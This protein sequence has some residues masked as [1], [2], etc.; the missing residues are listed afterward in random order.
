MCI[1][2]RADSPHAAEFSNIQE[3]VVL[4]D[5]TLI[6]KLKKDDANFPTKLLIG[7]LPAAL[8]EKNHD[9]SHHPV[10]SG[11]IQPVSYTHLDV[12]KRQ[13]DCRC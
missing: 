7:I 10:G 6:F 13:G 11:S 2:D 4:N 9:F 3:I 5:D 12:Y 1:R 8:V